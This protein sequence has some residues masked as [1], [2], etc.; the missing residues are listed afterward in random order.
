MGKARIT[1]L[2]ENDVNHIDEAGIPVRI[3]TLTRRWPLHI[4][5]IS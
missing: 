1:N 4:T 3:T 5:S 2:P